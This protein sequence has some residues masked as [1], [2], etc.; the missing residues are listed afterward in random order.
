M[1]R[2]LIELAGSRF[3]TPEATVILHRVGQS[4]HKVSLLEFSKTFNVP[5]PFPRWP[6]CSPNLHSYERWVEAFKKIA[7]KAAR[8]PLFP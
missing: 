7:K 6:G 5:L 4:D 3:E 8:R 1:K 2:R